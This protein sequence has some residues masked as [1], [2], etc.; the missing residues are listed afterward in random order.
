MA[1]GHTLYLPDEAE[2]LSRI[3]L[4]PIFFLILEDFQESYINQT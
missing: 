1:I 2:I 3:L 4:F